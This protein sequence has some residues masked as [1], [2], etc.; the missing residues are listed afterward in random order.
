MRF[1]E[2]RSK[3]IFKKYITR[4]SAV[5]CRFRWKNAR[6][7]WRFYEAIFNYML[8]MKQ[9]RLLSRTFKVVSKGLKRNVIRWDDQI[10]LQSIIHE[11]TLDSH[12]AVWNSSSCSI[13]P[14]RR[15]YRVCWNVQ[16]SPSE[17][18]RNPRFWWKKKNRIINKIILCKEDV[19]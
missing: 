10:S 14:T 6:T 1:V 18:N 7:E 13:G 12:T 3:S 19:Y 17:T 8:V 11:Q 9:R 15:Y 16:E 4:S 5:Y 2:S